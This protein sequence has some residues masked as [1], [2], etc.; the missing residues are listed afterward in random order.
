MSRELTPRGEHSGKQAAL[1]AHEP[2]WGLYPLIR[3]SPHPPKCHP[4][5]VSQC[6]CVS[7]TLTTRA[8]GR[9]RGPCVRWT[10]AT[11]ASAATSQPRV[12]QVRTVPPC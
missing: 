5:P 3:S 7:L 8:T 10:V 12:Q 11:K 2:A 4:A 6:P 1:L 9:E